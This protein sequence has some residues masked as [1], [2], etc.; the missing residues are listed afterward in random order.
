MDGDNRT[1][2]AVELRKYFNQCW[3]VASQIEWLNIA[4]PPCDRQRR[5]AWENIN[6]QLPIPLLVLSRMLLMRLFGWATKQVSERLNRRL[7][8]SGA[9]HPFSDPS[10]A[11]LFDGYH[12]HQKLYRSHLGGSDT[13]AC[14][15]RA[16]LIRLLWCASFHHLRLERG[17]S[18]SPATPRSTKSLHSPAAAHGAVNKA[19]ET[20]A[21]SI[22]VKNRDIDRN[23]TDRQEEH[24][25]NRDQIKRI[26]IPNSA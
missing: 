26:L 3:I 19:V 12:R 8:A 25:I 7:A 5:L 14:H 20:S 15:Q 4:E 6:F 24:G 13:Q 16:L 11:L 21:Y 22:S 10:S 17:F 1:S 23:S 9:Q 18:A 2:L